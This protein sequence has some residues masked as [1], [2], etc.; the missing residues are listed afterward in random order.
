MKWKIPLFKM[1]WDEDDLQYVHDAIAS[2]MNWAAGPNI[3]IFEDMITDYTGADFC[4]AC[5]SGTSALHA[6]LLA[7]EIGKGDE[8]IVPS[9]TFI[10]TANAPQ[11]VGA[12]PV[13]ADIE[14]DT[15]GLD[16]DDVLKKITKKTRAILPIHYGGCPCRIKEL[17]EIAD[18]HDLLLIE[19]A[20]ESFGAKVGE[21]QTGTFGE[22][23]ILSFCQNKIITTGEGGAIVTSSRNLYEKLKLIRSHGR[24]DTC[25]Y[26]ST[27][28]PL[29]YISLGYNFR[30][31][32]ISAALGI[33]QM[34]KIDHLI[35]M[36]RDLAMLY[37]KMLKKIPEICIPTVPEEYFHVYQ[38]F[39]ILVKERDSLIAHL[40]EKGIMTKLY[41]PPVHETHFYRK[42][43]KDRSILPVTDLISKQAISLPLYPGLLKEELMYISQEIG[44]FYWSIT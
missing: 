34:K 29:D 31:S 23:A 3:S 43:L 6:V 26:F 20:A 33:A 25:D 16:P 12:R 5:N 38:L 11:F 10:A 19:D 42:V 21:K 8:V 4:L 37:G 22:T 17:K 32:N 44:N 41:F 14:Q 24:L 28:T 27:T 9:F 40:E 2:G 15:F 1:Y 30:M 36:R 35:T 7:Y 18:D 13:F 39:T